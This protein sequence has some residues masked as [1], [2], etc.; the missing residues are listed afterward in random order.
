MA[1]LK[2]LVGVRSLTA[3]V[4]GSAPG[5]VLDLHAVARQEAENPAWLSRP[6]FVH[7]VLNRAMIVKHTLR[8]EGDG[9]PSAEARLDGTKIIFPFDPRDLALGGHVMFVDPGSL[10]ETLADHLDYG[11]LSITRDLEVLRLLDRLPTLDPF[12][13]REVLTQRNFQ[14]APC[15]FKFR[16]ADQTEMLDFV[17]DELEALAVLCFGEMKKGDERARRMSKL[18]LADQSSPELQPLQ[19]AL[20]MDAAEF[21]EA[22]FA[23]KGFLYYRWKIRELAPAI[24]ITRRE[25]ARA[26]RGRTSRWE[27]DVADLMQTAKANIDTAIVEA[28]IEIRH[29][30]EIYHD[31]FAAFTGQKDADSF[32][33]FLNTGS[34]LF[35]PLG[36]RIGRLEQVSGFWTHRFGGHQAGHLTADD[37]L[38]AL[39]DVLRE[40]ATGDEGVLGKQPQQVRWSGGNVAAVS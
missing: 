3:Y 25:I 14:V 24:K 6:M 18:L 7:P 28:C 12:L 4:E 11:Q 21:S 35:V 26:R 22:M 13:V 20:R 5:R 37:I 10:A 17:A 8:N 16:D 33:A 23:W 40:L 1:G 27:D 34:T 38:D 2:K 36:M 19:M 30:L 39:R 31:A 9:G 29:T 15:Y 32:R